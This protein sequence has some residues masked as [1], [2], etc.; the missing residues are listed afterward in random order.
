LVLGLFA[1]LTSVA[2]V[3]AFW[4][5]WAAIHHRNP[6][7]KILLASFVPFSFVWYYVR[8]AND[9]ERSQYRRS[10]RIAAVAVV[11]FTGVALIAEGGVVRTIAIPLLLACWYVIYLTAERERRHAG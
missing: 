4:M 7:S 11:T 10:I 3:G 6:I 2:T 5:M 1:L 8:I 9:R